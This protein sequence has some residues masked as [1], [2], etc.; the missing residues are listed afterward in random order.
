MRWKKISNFILTIIFSIAFMITTLLNML[1]PL[2]VNATGMINQSG[3]L[4][5]YSLIYFI[6]SIIII[7]GLYF[8]LRKRTELLFFVLIIVGITIIIAENFIWALMGS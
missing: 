2:H 4:L 7:W 5:K 1:G 8:F 3:S 6:F